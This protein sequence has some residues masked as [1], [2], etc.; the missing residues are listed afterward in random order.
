MGS[1]SFHFHY[2]DGNTNFNSFIINI[3]ILISMAQINLLFANATYDA[4]KQAGWIFPKSKEQEISVTKK[5][6]S[7]EDHI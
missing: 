6:S 2:F 3:L 1:I 5:T 4:T 7:N